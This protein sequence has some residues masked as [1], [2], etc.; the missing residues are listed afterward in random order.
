[1]SKWTLGE[2]IE[3]WGILAALLFAGGF[4]FYQLSQVLLE[5]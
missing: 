4:I 2:H 5:F 3:F 1:M